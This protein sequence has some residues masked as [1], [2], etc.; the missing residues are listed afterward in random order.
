[1][2]HLPLHFNDWLCRA[3][4]LDN[5]LDIIVRWNP[6][7]LKKLVQ[8]FP[9]ELYFMFHSHW[10]T[11]ATFV[12]TLI[13]YTDRISFLAFHTRTA[14]S[15]LWF[16]TSKIQESSRAPYSQNC[17]TFVRRRWQSLQ[18]ED[19]LP[20]LRICV[21]EMFGFFFFWLVSGWLL[22]DWGARA[23]NLKCNEDMK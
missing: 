9:I 17:L 21:S 8:N 12:W 22:N 4:H 14:P 19:T 6:Y 3:Y 7:C 23:I 16:K 18:A 10:V 15:A 2:G 20:P 1:M 11:F 13:E 5:P